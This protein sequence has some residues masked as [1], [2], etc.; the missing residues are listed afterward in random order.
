MSNTLSDQD[1]SALRAAPVVAA[2]TGPDR[3]EL[4]QAVEKIVDS[5]V[6]GITLRVHDERGK[7][8]GSAGVAELGGT[9]KPPIDGHVRIGSNTKTF[10]ATLVLQL[11][12]EGKI[13]LDV[14]A[15][16]YLPE[17]PLDTRITVRMLLQH[18]SGVFN[19][20]GEVYA[21]GTVVHG[22]PVPF[23]ATGKEW[24]DNR[25][26]TY[27]P[28]ELV[29]LALS[30]PARFEPGAGWSYSNTNYVLARLLIEKVTGRSLAEEMQR[31]ILGPLGLAGTVVPD[32]SPEIPEPHA[33]T[34]YRYEDAGRQ[35]TIDITRYNPSWVSTG[36]DMISTTQDLHTFIAALNGGTLL[37]AEV[38]AEMR[39][40]QPTGIP[41]M[42][43]GLGVFVVTTE[44]GGTL[45]SHNGGNV[46]AAALMY[47][48]PDGGKTLTAA[49][50][51]VDDADMS[52][53]AA[54]R[55]A[56]QILVDAVF[57][58]G[59]TEPAQPAH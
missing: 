2:A 3:P 6:A 12:A 25:F 56:Q 16:E 32:A 15:V 1:K 28:Q 7:W 4:Q 51:Y 46:G 39:T 9:A 40:A 50:N 49:L 27:R 22:V 18:T 44:D 59:H 31:R 17:F 8:V 54:F 47:S 5:G 11:A 29:E 42:D 48:T 24:V 33:H 58:A 36:G 35:K 10:T 19:F 38:L 26:R 13:G 14:P 37:P 30:R 20:T 53:A 45:I 57:C 23:G 55:N 52:L 41:N 43:Y 21:D 34:Y